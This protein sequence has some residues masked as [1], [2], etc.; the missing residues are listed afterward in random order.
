VVFSYISIKDK[1]E[2]T[3]GI[4]KILILFGNIDEL[5]GKYEK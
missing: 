2:Y 5:V 4:K 3:K 1:P